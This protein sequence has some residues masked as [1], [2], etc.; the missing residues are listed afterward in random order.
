MPSLPM[1]AIA[2]SNQASSSNAMEADIIVQISNPDGTPKA[3]LPTN[4]QS[5][6]LGGVILAPFWDFLTVIVPPSFEQ[7]LPIV[8]VDSFGERSTTLVR[9]RGQLVVG[10]IVEM[11]AGVYEVRVFPAVGLKGQRRQGLN[12]IA[13]VYVFRLSCFTFG[14]AKTPQNP[15]GIQDRGDILGELV[16]K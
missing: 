9:T 8:Q 2:V 11:L 1:Q 16:I 3:N 6:P 14:A 7:A 10:G 13:G 4:L 5:D 15:M 12:W